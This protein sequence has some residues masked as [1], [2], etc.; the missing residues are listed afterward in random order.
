M[1]DDNVE[2]QPPA[3]GQ[4]VLT[5]EA[6]A[7]AAPAAGAGEPP[8]PGEVKAP[9]GPHCPVKGCTG[10]MRPLPTPSGTAYSRCNFCGVEA[11]EMVFRPIARKIEYSEP[12]LSDDAVCAY[13]PE[14]KAVN[15][16]AGTGN[17]I[18]PLCSV[19]VG[20]AVYSVQFLDSPRG[21]DVLAGK[22]DLNLPRPERAMTLLMALLVLPPLGLGLWLTS[23]IWFPYGIY[24]WRQAVRQRL[25]NPLYAQF[26]SRTRLLV[27]A[28]I[29]MCIGGLSAASSVYWMFNWFAHG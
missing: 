4:G 1:V 24:Q 26:V 17:F 19:T 20:G 27:I 6:S 12:A 18:C 22:F 2:V 15:T 13:H 3:D 7:S 21:K 23:V 28:I 25:A 10:S 9:V 8:R 16:C 14:K 5:A 11:I 29:F